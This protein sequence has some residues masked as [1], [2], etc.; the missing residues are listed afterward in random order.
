M[1]FSTKTVAIFLIL[2]NL[3]WSGGFIANKIALQQFT[4]GQVLFGRVV[5]A[6]FCY[7]LLWRKYMPL[8]AYKT[9]DWRWL[10][11][12]V[13]CEP[14]LLFAFESA[15]LQYTTASQ[16][17]MIVAC[18]PLTVAAGA[19][20]FYREALQRRGIAGIAVAVAGVMLVSVS[21]QASEAAPNPLL[22][23]LLICCAVLSST[24]YALIIKKLSAR[25]SFLFL[26]AMQCIGGTVFFLPL[27]FSAPWPAD[28]PA[29][30]WAS[31]LYLGLGVTFFTY[32]IMNY[33]I[34]RL[35]A[36][37]V[38]L[39]SNLIPVFTLLLAFAILDERLL[40]LQYAGAALVL[41][42]VFLA[43]A[44]EESGA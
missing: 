7:L 22:G 19:W 2:A 44:P 3:V 25:Y 42:G 8:R 15:S 20:L 26:A 5:F 11:A 41:G 6:A 1:A 23:N 28:V 16:A 10:L 14:C 36:G 13:I 21:G 35:K 29:G 30:A 4:L 32:M 27:A 38:S 9:G 40:P 24:G 12:L 43:G 31:L 33:A 34:S 18:Y 37:H 17:G 39:F